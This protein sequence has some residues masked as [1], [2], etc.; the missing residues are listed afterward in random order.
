MQEHFGKNMNLAH[1]KLMALLIHVLC[2]MQTVSLHKLIDTMSTAVDVDSNL[3]WLRRFFAKYILDHDIIASMI[4]SLLPVKIGL[5]LS[6]DCTK[7][8]FGVFN[9]NILMLGEHKY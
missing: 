2:V 7:W 9:I 4:F 3:R 6:M 5:V 8:K 1:I